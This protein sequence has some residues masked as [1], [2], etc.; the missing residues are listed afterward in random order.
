MPD[1]DRIER[2]ETVVRSLNQQVADLRGELAALRG[3]RPSD[4]LP[5]RPAGPAQR[6]AQPERTAVARVAAPVR[7]PAE[8][9][10][11]GGFAAI[12]L[13][14]LVGRYGTI[15]LATLALLAGMGTFL[16]WAIA[17]GLLGPAQR[18]VLGAIG[19]AVVAGA[20][21]RLRSRGTVRFGNT[22]LAL[23]LALL[24]L[25]LWAA[26]PRLHV[27]LP[28]FALV[29][30]A[31]ASVALAMVALRT[32]DEPLFCVGL[33]GALAA[34]FVV[35]TIGG[36]ASVLAVYGWIVIAAGVAAV[37]RRSWRFAI[38]ILGA[39]CALYAGTAQHLI[40]ASSPWT[41]HS[42]PTLFALASAW[43]ALAWG[44]SEVRARL[45][46]AF[47]VVA[48][49]GLLVADL[50]TGSQAAVLALGLAGTITAIAALRLGLVS[51]W[52]KAGA[53]VLLPLGFLG[54]TLRGLSHPSAVA[55]AAVGLLWAA[56]AFVAAWSDE[57]DRD[58][59]FAGAAAASAVA[60]ILALDQTPA[61]C[62]VALA[63]HAS[64][65]SALLNRRRAMAIAIPVAIV[66]ALASEWALVLLSGR[67]AYAYTPFLTAPS[68]AALAVVLGWWAFSRG[69]RRIPVLEASVLM[70][71]AILPS[72]AAFV[73]LRQELTGAFTPDIS[74]FLLIMFY[75]LA[76]I[77]AIF[78]GR[79]RSLPLAR[80][81]GLALA[82]YAAIKAL[83][84]AWG[85]SAVGL[86]VGS[87]I[88]AGVFIALV[89]Y[90]YRAR[91]GGRGRAA[92]FGIQEAK[93]GEAP[94][95]LSSRS[96]GRP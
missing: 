30:V 45:A 10:T 49:A 9:P 23:A 35:S 64:L 31:A 95:G 13:E 42:V 96:Q 86:R 94:E 73:W 4:E 15:A 54:A 52:W 26:G 90:W 3:G 55:G 6:A 78:Y 67:T 22:L 24:H 63:T 21:W 47:L 72:L 50:G 38:A 79:L 84:H 92:G 89:A 85:L 82:C 19:A 20:G 76:G 83:V 32:P 77:G 1:S 34:P 68:A 71:L 44:V 53:A 48:A 36:S 65:F 18:V 81:A 27:I 88:L 5:S 66:L 7:P 51:Q 62:V 8:R 43:A 56:I 57:E 69:A 70:V 60:V 58:L 40:N 28:T 14:E 59:H 80:A 87:C 12:D 25:D 46:L 75:A 74:V 39:G 37:S 17:H 61:W 91:E 2:L 33:G 16:T 41:E 11:R 29:I 93:P